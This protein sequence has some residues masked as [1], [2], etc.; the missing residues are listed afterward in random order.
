[1]Q[2]IDCVFQIVQQFPCEFEFNER[3]LITVLDHSNISQF[4]TFIG[5]CAKDREDHDLK[6]QEK[7]ISL[8]T[9]IY[10]HKSSFTS[11][12]YVGYQDKKFML[13]I[14][15]DCL[16]SF[17]KPNTS[18][19]SIRLWTNY[20]L[21]FDRTVPKGDLF[22]EA[23]IW[24]W[25]VFDQCDSCYLPSSS[26]SSPERSSTSEIPTVNHIETESNEYEK[27]KF[28]LQEERKKNEMLMEKLKTLE[29]PN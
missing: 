25:N 20:Y 22:G 5:N 27:L 8:W 10:Q 3:F 17:L 26:S 29:P 13:A 24:A 11:P 28:L 14:E 9:F 19:K 15:N 12:K 1:M 4:G 16:A 7:T 21:R 18:L 6:L 2:F 23:D